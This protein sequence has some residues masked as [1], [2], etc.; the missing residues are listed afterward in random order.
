MD[1]RDL[2]KKGVDMALRALRK[3]NE[4]LRKAGVALAGRLA[5][6]SEGSQAWI[7]RSALRELAARRA[8]ARR[9]R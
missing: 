2:V 4:A 5:G 8:G 3:R 1:E 9:D 6:S 7:R